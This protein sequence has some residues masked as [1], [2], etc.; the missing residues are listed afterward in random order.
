M[1]TDYQSNVEYMR[2]ET[3]VQRTTLGDMRFNRL[4]FEVNV[5]G[6]SLPKLNFASH[7]KKILRSYTPHPNW[8]V[9]LCMYAP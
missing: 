6:Q 8:V 7:V 5:D 3:D 2:Q 4:K 1:A 9:G